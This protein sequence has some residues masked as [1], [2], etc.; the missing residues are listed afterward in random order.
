MVNSTDDSLVK[1]QLQF[2]QLVVNPNLTASRS[3]RGRINASDSRFNS[4]PKAR[5]AWISGVKEDI[6]ADFG[7]D[8][9]GLI[10][11]KD[12]V[13]LNIENPRFE[14]SPELELNLEVQETTKL[15][16]YEQANQSTWKRKGADGEF[17]LH[18]GL[19]IVS[20][21]DV[22]AGDAQHIFLKSDVDAVVVEQASVMSVDEPAGM[23][24]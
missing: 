4:A 20:K 13:E 16:T 15:N 7:I 24:A 14:D 21:T 23:G 10:N 8:L 6:E 1:V 22:V 19:P 5:K 9:S 17:I 18:N 2:S 12:V 3:I 11:V